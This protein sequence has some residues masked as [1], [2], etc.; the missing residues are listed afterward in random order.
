MGRSY[1][2]FVAPWYWFMLLVSGLLMRRAIW[3][4]EEKRHRRIEAVVNRGTADPNLKT[5]TS[6][7]TIQ[8]DS[9]I[10]NQA[11]SDKPLEPGEPDALGLGTIAAGL[12][13]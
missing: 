3:P 1:G 9:T 11:I 5:G 2:R 4:E 12:S 8:T 13:F 10:G 6:K 7:A